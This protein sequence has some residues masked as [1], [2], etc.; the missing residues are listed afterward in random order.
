MLKKILLALC[1]ALI[2][3][4]LFST[5]ALAN[6]YAIGTFQPGGSYGGSAVSIQIE[7]LYAPDCSYGGHTNQTIWVGTDNTTGAYWA[8]IG[9]TYGYHGSCGLTYYWARNNPKYGYQDYSLHSIGSIGS[10]HAFESQ[11]VYVGEYDVYLDYTKVGADVGANPWTK[12]IQTGLEYT[13]PGSTLSTTHF[14][15][16]QFRST[17]CCSWYYWSSGGTQ[18]TYIHTWHWTTQWDHGYNQN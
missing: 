11:E 6:D 15:W 9:Y 1:T 16:H 12:G 3:A 7:N 5:S 13:D 18:N 14:D 2:P 8:E 17:G 4:I 10:S